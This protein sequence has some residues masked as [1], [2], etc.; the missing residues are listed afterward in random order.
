MA[1]TT[2]RKD[3][4]GLVKIRDSYVSTVVARPELVRDL[5]IGVPQGP[6]ELR[7]AQRGVDGWG[8]SGWFGAPKTKTAVC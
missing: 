8:G 4:P 1:A 7:P 2:S 3:L 6:A 5:V